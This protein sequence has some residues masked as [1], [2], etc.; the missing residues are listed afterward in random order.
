M[1]D[2]P[3]TPAVDPNTLVFKIPGTETNI[4]IDLAQ[5]PAD[6]RL[7]LLGQKVTENISNRV[8]V[9]GVRHT[10]ACEAFDQYDAAQAADPLQTAVPKPAGERPAID[11][12]ALASA[13]RADLYAGKVGERAK[14][15]GK[16]KVARDPIIAAVTQAVV[17]E[18]FDNTKATTP[19]FKY[20]DAVKLVGGDGVAYLDAKIAE[21]VAAGADQA[22]LLKMKEDKYMR[23][24][25]IMLGQEVPKNVKEGVSIL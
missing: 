19:G 5:I 2:T 21:K 23:P 1:T 14:G 17:R 20:T 22:A 9:A 15:S 11:L 24:A 16:T 6:A 12:L 7:K 8:R 13:A 18:L 3:E 4:G 10:K 25:R